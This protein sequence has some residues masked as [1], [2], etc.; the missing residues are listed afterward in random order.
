MEKFLIDFIESPENR[1]DDISGKEGPVITISRECG[2]SSNRIA[3]KLSKILSGYSYQSDRKLSVDWKWVNKE[4]IEKAA[5][6]L[7][8]SPDVIKDVFLQEARLSLHKVQNAFSTDKMYDADDQEV[9]DTLTQIIKE[10]AYQGNCVI[11][12]RA[13]NVIVGDISSKLRIKLQAPLDWRINRIR[14]RSAMS[15]SEAE[16]YV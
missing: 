6:E 8:I 14:H 3:I 1:I 11:V 13:A 2:C 12:G 5:E 7:D 15:Y 16:D 10:L 4:V 9:I